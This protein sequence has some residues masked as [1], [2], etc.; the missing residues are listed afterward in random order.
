[1]KQGKLMAIVFALAAGILVLKGHSEEPQKEPK[2]LNDAITKELSELMKRKL[3]NSQKVL[4]GIAIN[5]FDK[6]SKHAEELIAISKQA[7]WKV[8]KTADYDLYSN[9]FRRNAGDLIQKARDKNLD[10]AALAYV[11]MTLTCVKCHKYVRENRR[12]Q[13]DL[14]DQSFIVR[15]RK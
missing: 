9:D 5:D 7:E 11:D 8:L 12:A 14:L 15:T 6:I 4:E 3:E 1:M 10:G 2:K 13:L